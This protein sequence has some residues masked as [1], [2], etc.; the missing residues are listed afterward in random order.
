MCS[1][2]CSRRSGN[3][4]NCIMDRAVILALLA[5]SFAPFYHIWSRERAKYARVMHCSVPVLPQCSTLTFLDT[6]QWAS[7]RYKSLAYKVKPPVQNNARIETRST[8][9]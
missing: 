6:W 7:K 1:L 4:K 5:S 2:L 8:K 3:Q 9:G